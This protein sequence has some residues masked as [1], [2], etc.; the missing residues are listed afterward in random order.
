M[1]VALS[2]AYFFLGGLATNWSDGPS[3]NNDFYPNTNLEVE[4]LTTTTNGF[5]IH[6]PSLSLSYVKKTRGNNLLVHVKEGSFKWVHLSEGTE[7][8]DLIHFF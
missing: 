6:E 2:D 7:L 1:L 4:L 3:G 5:S 8:E